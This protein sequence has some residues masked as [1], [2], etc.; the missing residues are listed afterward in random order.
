VKIRDMRINIV[1][2]PPQWA[3]SYHGIG[4]GVRRYVTDVAG[5]VIL[6]CIALPGFRVVRRRQNAIT[7]PP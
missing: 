4:S 5:R 7:R 6:A 1:R 2:R 3:N